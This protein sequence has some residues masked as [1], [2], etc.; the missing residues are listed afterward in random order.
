MP[1]SIGGRGSSRAATLGSR[2]R[3]SLQ[4][5]AGEVLNARVD[6]HP[7]AQ[8]RIERNLIFQ[9]S[10]EVGPVS[11]PEIRAIQWVLKGRV[12]RRANE[13]REVVRAQ[14]TARGQLHR[15]REVLHY[16]DVQDIGV[17][18]ELYGLV[19]RGA[20]SKDQ[21]G[22]LV[23]IITEDFLRL[24]F[25]REF[26]STCFALRSPAIRTGN[27]PRSGPLRPVGGKEISKPQG[28]SPVCRA[29]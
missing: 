11:A 8:F 25:S 28:S 14:Y 6:C 22:A 16:R 15:E 24:I 21:T 7:V 27:P 17:A 19:V 13:Y 10:L 20:Q 29:I 5:S 2:C 12:P 26:Q 4:N 18:E 3:Q 23:C 9:V 1:A